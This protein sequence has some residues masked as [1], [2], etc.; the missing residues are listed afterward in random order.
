MSD[1]AVIRSFY[2]RMSDRDLEGALE[3]AHP[4]FVFDWSNSR[5]TQPGVYHGWDGLRSYWK[6]NE[7]A[8]DEFTIELR[9][10]IPRGDG[11]VVTLNSV[12]GRG[13][14]SGVE[15]EAVGAMVWWVADGKLLRGK[16]YQS[17]EEALAA[18]EASP[19]E[20][21]PA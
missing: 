10:V 8:W 2:D 9:E 21:R 12:R 6:Q 20:G 1:E 16:L 11:C 13:K 5:G 3:Y 7:D 17:R 4:D 18:A 14:G 15:V 19:R